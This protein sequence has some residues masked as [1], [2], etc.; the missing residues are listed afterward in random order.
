MKKR[1]VILLTLAMSI[2]FLVGCES[3]SNP[4]TTTSNAST[5]TS[6]A[7]KKNNILSECLN[8]DKI[9]GYEVFGVDKE[10]IPEYVYFF[11]DG[12]VS[13]IPGSEFDMNMGD[14][15]KLTDKEIW[16]KYEKMRKTYKEDYANTEQKRIE[17]ET[18]ALQQFCEQKGK[19]FAYCS[20]SDIKVPTKIL[21]VVKGKTYEE[22]NNVQTSDVIKDLGE[23][24]EFQEI[25]VASAAETVLM[26]YIDFSDTSGNYSEDELFWK[27]WIENP[28]FSERLVNDAIAF[29]NDVE[30]EVEDIKSEVSYKGPFLDL[31]F[32]LV[33]ETDSSGNE[34]ATERLVY[35]T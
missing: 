2:T 7:N 4:S 23:K 6:E 5:T 31:P 1:I 21:E 33:I 12:K 28:I 34:V 27:G 20:Y 8:K 29:Y 24:N 19:Y 17:K 32:E 18:Y 26:N 25:S 16:K 14:F 11:K 30:K 15:A 3:N 9:I 13:I 22:F 10:S 35:P